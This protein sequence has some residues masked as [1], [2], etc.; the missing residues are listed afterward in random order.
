M[1]DTL[2]YQFVKE[3]IPSEIKRDSILN[4]I[5]RDVNTYTHGFHKYPAK[6]IP[7]IPK[8]AIEKYLNGNKRKI[9]L[10]PFCGSGT[11]LVESILAG[12]DVIGIDIDPLVGIDFKSKNYKS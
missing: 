8:W 1:I 6:F 5:T 3:I 12:H 10:D 4:I 9:I 7:H 11:T 2:E